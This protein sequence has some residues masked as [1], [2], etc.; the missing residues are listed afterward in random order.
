MTSSQLEAINGLERLLSLSPTFQI[1]AQVD[2]NLTIAQRVA[3]MLPR[4]YF[5]EVSTQDTTDPGSTLNL[6]TPYAIIMGEDDFYRKTSEGYSGT[7]LKAGS[8]LCILSA[9]PKTPNDHKESYRSFLDYASKIIDEI[10][11]LIP[12]I[13]T[14][15]SE[16]Y[17]PFESVANFHQPFR[18][19]AQDRGSDDFWT[20]A[21]IFAYDAG[22]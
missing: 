2:Q 22:R 12:S 21:W 16:P 18:P 8:V 15:S 7:F 14:D 13:P 17:F 11:D 1:E 6:K 3:L 4:I 10:T 19:G 9:S 20:A 5:G